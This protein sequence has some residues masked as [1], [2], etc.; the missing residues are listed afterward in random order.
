MTSTGNINSIAILIGRIVLS[1]A[2]ANKLGPIHDL[3]VDPIKGELAGLAVQMPDETLRLIDYREIYSFGPDAVMINSDESATQAQD[4]ALQGLPLAKQ[5][6]MGVKV[7]T[8]VGKVLGQ[9]ANIY[10]RLAET[11]PLFYE[12]RSSLLDKLLGH[13]LYFPASFGCAL[14]EDAARLVVANDAAEKAD[15]TLEALATRL[16]GPPKDEDPVVVVRSRGH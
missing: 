11:S 1:R 3:I 6:L 4:S 7:I 15:H 13:S 2:T 10:I 16:F 8:E 14:S 9:I 5:H 12:V